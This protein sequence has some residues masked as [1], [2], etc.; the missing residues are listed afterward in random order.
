MQLLNSFLISQ[1][2]WINSLPSILTG[3]CDVQGF[4][5]LKA[6]VHQQM[7]YCRL[8]KFS[9]GLLSVCPLSGLSLSKWCVPLTSM[10][11]FVLSLHAQTNLERT[12]G[13]RLSGIYGGTYLGVFVL[14]VYVCRLI[15][16][17]G[18]SVYSKI[19]FFFQF[20]RWCMYFLFIYIYIFFNAK[21]MHTKG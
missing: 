1:I 13:Y 17:Q 2:S 19:P 5:T 11:S 12:P 21:M 9:F 20:S 18:S 14:S 16:C 15:G 10:A 3:M 6:L 7:Q 4:S 8:W